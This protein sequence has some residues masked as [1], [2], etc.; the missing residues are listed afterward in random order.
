[1]QVA[2]FGTPRFAVPSLEHL[3]TSHHRVAGVITQPDRARG[4][5]QKPGDSPVKDTAVRRGLPL[6]QPE[7]LRDEG[8]LTSFRALDADIGV[9]AAYGRILPETL[10][11][12]PRHGLINVHASLLP[13]YRGAAPI[14]RAVM[15]GEA[16]TGVSIMR[17]VRELDAGPVF[18]TRAVVIG[19]NETSESLERRLAADGAELLLEVLDEIEA[20]RAREIPQDHGGATY[21]PRIAK[22]EGLID[23]ERPAREIHNRIR[24]LHP[25]PHA[26]SY[27]NRDRYIILESS[28][29]TDARASDRSGTEDRR[30]GEIVDVSRDAIAVAAGGRTAIRILRIQP[31]GRRPM[32]VREFLA[33]HGLTPGMRFGPA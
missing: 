29:A 4:R 24:G 10:I 21:A 12:I 19:P 18:A 25:W 2:F 5:G 31:E 6:L 13:R 15:A 30:S 1:M 32:A 7:R 27:L 22:E 3:L 11:A 14:Q 23:W 20:G 33:G 16:E 8:F 9:V 26:F 17:I 28:V